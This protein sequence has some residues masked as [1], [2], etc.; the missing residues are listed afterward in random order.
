MHFGSL[1]RL[2]LQCPSRA[3]RKPTFAFPCCFLRI[4]LPAG[5]RD[6]EHGSEPVTFWHSTPVQGRHSRSTTRLSPP[7]LRVHE[8][9]TSSRRAPRLISDHTKNSVIEE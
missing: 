9:F 8:L 7:F 5:G 1:Q 2:A 4:V 3:S 6:R